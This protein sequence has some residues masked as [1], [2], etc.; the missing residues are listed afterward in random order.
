[1]KLNEFP[2]QIA[3][4]AIKQTLKEKEQNN[5][6]EEN[7]N[8]IKMILPYEKGISEAISRMCKRFNIKITHTKSRSLNQLLVKPAR[9]KKR[10]RRRN[11]T[12]SHVQG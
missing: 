11:G 9:R 1:M 6:N 5:V 12:R 7:E 2:K 4:N 10:K 8:M 3:K